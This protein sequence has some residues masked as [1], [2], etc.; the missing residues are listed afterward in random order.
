MYIICVFPRCFRLVGYFFLVHFLQKFSSTLIF[1]WFY[2]VSV[3]VQTPGFIPKLRVV[4]KCFVRFFSTKTFTLLV[5]ICALPKKT[6]VQGT[7]YTV[8]YNV[9]IQA[10]ENFLQ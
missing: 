9:Y 7:T 10:D 3:V 5:P 1:I 6:A 8:K 4:P 2:T